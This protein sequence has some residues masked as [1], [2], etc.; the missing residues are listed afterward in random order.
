MIEL[1]QGIGLGVAFGVPSGICAARTVERAQGYG[2]RAGLASGW[3]SALAA[4]LY[5]GIGWLLLG[6]AQPWLRENTAVCGLLGG[7]LLLA[8]GIG[9]LVCPQRE[10]PWERDEPKFGSC[11]LG[12]LLLGLTSPSM[13][14]TLSVGGAVLHMVPVSGAGALVL[15]GAGVWIGMMAWY[16]ALC[17]FAG[18]AKWRESQFRMEQADRWMG[19]LLAAEGIV[20]AV[21][22]GWP[23]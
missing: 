10:L 17:L 21:F 6:I 3:G 13:L 2:G 7:V 5:G 11:F 22:Q 14:V 9:R 8:L 16:G 4:L 1:L 15:T 20:A 18:L 23:R 12:G 19:L